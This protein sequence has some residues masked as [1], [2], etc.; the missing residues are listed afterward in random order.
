MSIGI[1]I[2]ALGAI[3]A[4][5]TSNPSYS[6]AAAPGAPETV[7]SGSFSAVIAWPEPLKQVLQTLELEALP[8]LR[9][10][11]EAERAEMMAT[12]RAAEVSLG[13]RSKLRRV[14]LG[15]RPPPGPR[16]LQDEITERQRSTSHEP[17]RRLQAG[18]L[19]QGVPGVPQD[20]FA[21]PKGRL[22][23]RLQSH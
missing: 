19:T 10:L 13:A 5:A 1:A 18:L 15:T 4:A 11:D 3:S 12:L 16:P 14:I 2:A 9:E 6:V 21:P 20:P 7:A 8:D 17:T 22:G 23:G